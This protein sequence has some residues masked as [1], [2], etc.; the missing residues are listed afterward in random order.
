MTKSEWIVW[1]NI[2]RVKS[3]EI[4]KNGWPDFLVAHEDK[5]YCL[6]VKTGT[7]PITADQKRMHALL[8]RKGIETYII[9][10]GWCEK[11]GKRFS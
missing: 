7:E 8:A 3:C 4:Q 2:D 9:R 10:D 5:L 1:K 11:L 6:E